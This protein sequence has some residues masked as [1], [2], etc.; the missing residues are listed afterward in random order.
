[1]IEP[2]AL[3]DRVREL[4]AGDRSLLEQHPL[5]GGTRATRASSIAFCARSASV[6]PSSTST[7]VRNRPEPPRLRGG[8]MPSIAAG[9][10]SAVLIAAS[11]GAEM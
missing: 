2:V 4:L 11:H 1:M 8:V 3:G 10:L 6:N 5:R 9:G 7:S